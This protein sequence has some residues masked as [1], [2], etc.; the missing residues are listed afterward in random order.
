RAMP[1]IIDCRLHTLQQI[2][3][4]A[5]RMPDVRMLEICS[6]V[7]DADANMPALRI[8]PHTRCAG[9]RHAP[10]D[11]MSGIIGEGGLGRGGQEGSGADSDLCS[12]RYRNLSRVSQ[13]LLGIG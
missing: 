8:L 5:Q 2:D 1:I 6:C 13:Q 3:A 9:C 7:Y 12:R 4:L 11:S 10:G